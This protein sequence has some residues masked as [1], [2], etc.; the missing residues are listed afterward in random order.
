MKPGTW[1]VASRRPNATAA[2]WVSVALYAGAIYLL[3]STPHPLGIDRLPVFVDKIAHA[4]VF[5]GL[6]FVLWNALRGSMPMATTRR[7]SV[8]AIVMTTL[9]GMS[10]EFHQS[11][12]PGRTMDLF[13]LIADA[14]G[15][16]LVQGTLWY[17]Q[18][19][20][21]AGAVEARS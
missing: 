18:R 19:V 17:S 7:L 14:G 5:G 13:D 4:A 16:C 15:A 9:Y 8:L 1:H 21:K 12:V 3:S 6:S 10:D 2:W 20:R 11:F